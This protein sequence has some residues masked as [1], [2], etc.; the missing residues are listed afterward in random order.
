M[1]DEN[2]KHFDGYISSITLPN[3]KMYK[4]Q[5]EIVEV[6]PMQCPR[7]GGQVELH[8]GIGSCKFC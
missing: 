3:G 4:L 7:C 6:Y 8:C 2:G 5:C 1:I